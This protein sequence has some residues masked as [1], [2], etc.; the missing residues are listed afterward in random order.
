[1]Q[2]EWWL[3]EEHG[4]DG[5]GDV[6]GDGV[7]QEAPLGMFDGRRWDVEGSSG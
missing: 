3:V 6:G 7:W 2:P 1:M 5:G 4:D